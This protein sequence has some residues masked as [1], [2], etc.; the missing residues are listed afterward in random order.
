MA[1]IGEFGNSVY[2]YILAGYVE[3][4]TYIANSLWIFIYAK[5]PI[6]IMVK[7]Y[8]WRHSILFHLTASLNF[9]IASSRIRE[10]LL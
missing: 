6:V 9:T 4:M 7:I 1:R 10:C 5:V 8:N 2:L 3:R